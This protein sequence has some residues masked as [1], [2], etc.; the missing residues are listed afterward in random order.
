MSDLE[1]K[2]RIIAALLEDNAELQVENVALREEAEE[3]AA[4]INELLHVPTDIFARA[5]ADIRSLDETD[6]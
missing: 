3:L 5:R 6:I 2:D 4:L 1:R